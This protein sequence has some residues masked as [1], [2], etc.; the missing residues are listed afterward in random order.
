MVKMVTVLVYAFILAQLT[1]LFVLASRNWWRGAPAFMTFLLLAALQAVVGAVGYPHAPTDTLWWRWTWMPMELGMILAGAAAAM[2]IVWTRSSYALNF[3][4][5]TARLIFPFLT[6]ALVGYRWRI[7]PHSTWFGWF[8]LAREWA[9][10]GMT[11]LVGLVVT[12][13][14]LPARDPKPEPQ[15]LVRHS[16]TFAALLLSH[17]LIAPLVRLGWNKD[18]CQH[19][20]MAI[21]IVCCASWIMLAIPAS[22]GPLSVIDLTI[23]QDHGERAYHV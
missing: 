17:A 6:W 3:H 10:V 8:V 11:I 14:A 12:F 22:V 2:E 20:Y 18:T 5:F 16:W 15:S 1:A 9:W 23:P 4:R 7:I 21:V 13:F 19:V